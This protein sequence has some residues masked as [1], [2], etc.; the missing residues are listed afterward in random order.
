MRVCECV[1]KKK[2]DGLQVLKSSMDIVSMEVQKKIN[3]Y[4][5]DNLLD[6]LHT[7]H[8]ISFPH[9]SFYVTFHFVFTKMTPSTAVHSP[10]FYLK[11]M[12]KFLL[13]YCHPHYLVYTG[14]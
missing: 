11:Y 13:K 1:C 6:E 2:D 7:M 3:K 14:R 8:T 12:H 10:Y 5:S 9:F 4:Q